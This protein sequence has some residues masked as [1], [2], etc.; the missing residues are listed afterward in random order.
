[1]EAHRLRDLVIVIGASNEARLNTNQIKYTIV[2]AHA[3]LQYA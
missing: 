2:S 3:V 1:M